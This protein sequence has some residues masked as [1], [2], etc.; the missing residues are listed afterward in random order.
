MPQGERLDT[1]AGQILLMALFSTVRKLRA[2]DG[3][4]AVDLPS[5]YVL[6]V[7]REHP[8]IRVSELAGNVGLDASTVSRHIRSLE[9]VGYLSRVVDPKDR[10]ASCLELTAD[11]ATVIAAAFET[12]AA[13]MLAAMDD[14]APE[15]QERFIE[16]V[17]RY[18]E[19]FDRVVAH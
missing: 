2:R 6:N 8:G 4:E 16:L 9:A 18:S 14:W 19:D 5:I 12:R 17:V 11:G 13:I 3:G 15:D 10:R 7:V 1:H